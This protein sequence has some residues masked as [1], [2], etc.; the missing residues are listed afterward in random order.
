MSG[1]VRTPISPSSAIQEYTGQG[2]LI[3]DKQHDEA[4]FAPVDEAADQLSL[5]VARA[6]DD[7]RRNETADLAAGE[8]IR[9]VGT[10]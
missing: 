4:C 7:Y 3:T 9:G 6:A 2:E 8:S 5:L 1:S 10:L